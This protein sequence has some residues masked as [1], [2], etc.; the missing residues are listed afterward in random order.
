MSVHYNLSDI[1]QHLIDSDLIRLR[2]LLRSHDW[3]YEFSDDHSVWLRGEQMWAEIRSLRDS[4]ND[5]G[6][7]ADDIVN[8]YSPK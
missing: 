4:L 7:N 3:C 8:E 2:K 5:R 6:V 1:E